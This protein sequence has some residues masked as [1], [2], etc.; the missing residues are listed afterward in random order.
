[1]KT[2]PGSKVYLELPGVPRQWYTIVF[3]GPKSLRLKRNDGT[4]IDVSR[5][6][7]RF[8]LGLSASP[9]DPCDFDADG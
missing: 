8:Q 4:T 1:M 7:V 2:S 3:V 9:M 5:N 6:K